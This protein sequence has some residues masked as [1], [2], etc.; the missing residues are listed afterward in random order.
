MDVP[1]AT[2]SR[3][4]SLSPASHDNT[5]YSP[6][7]RWVSEREPELGLGTIQGVGARRVSVTFPASGETR[8]YVREGAPLRRVAFRVGERLRDAGNQPLTVDAVI[9]QNG[10]LHYRCGDRELCETE[11]SGTLSFS[12]PLDRFRLGQ[13]DTPQVFD[14]RFAALRHQSRQRKSPIRGFQGGRIDLLPHQLSIASEVSARLAP[15]VLLA[16][17]VGL[18]KTIEAGLIL[19]RLLLSGRAQRA[20]ILV[21]ESLIHQWFLEL[22]RRFNLW[23]SIYDEARCAAIEAGP[24]EANPFLEDQRVICPVGLFTEH[25]QRLQQA[26][27]AGWDLVI[28]DEAHH[29]AWSPEG[30]SAAYAVVEALGQRVPGLLLLT[31]TPEQLGMASHFARLRLLDPDRFHDLDAFLRESNSYRELAD[32]AERLEGGHTLEALEITRLARILSEPEAQIRSQLEAGDPAARQAWIDA[33]LDQHGTGRVMFRNTRATVAGFPKRIPHLYPLA[34]QEPLNK[35]LLKEWIAD[36]KAETSFRPDFSQDPRIAWL[37]GQLHELGQEK[38]L[39][40]CR[41]RRKAEAIAAALK[42]QLTVKMAV[43]H[44]GLTLIQRDRGAAWFAEPNGA[45]LLICSEIGS[46]G[47]NFQFAHHLVL[48]DLPLDPG[49]LEQR[50]G[51]LDRIGQRADIQIHVPYVLGSPQALLARWYHEGLNAFAENLQGGRELLDRFAPRLMALAQECAT[52]REEVERAMTALI[53]ETQAARS[54]VATR[55]ERG[56]D[57]LLERNSFRPKR[58]AQLIQEIRLQD[59]RRL[60]EDFLLA[61]LELFFIDVDEIAPRTYHIGSTELLADALPGLG[62]DGLTVTCDRARALARED[63][64]FLTWDHPLITGALDLLLGSDPGSTSFA[65]WP[66]DQASGLYLEA[67]YVLECVAP[68]SLH[69]DRFLPPTPVRVMVN[70]RGQDVGD[71]LPPRALA[72]LLKAPESRAFLEQPELRET[73]LPRLVE[74]TQRLADLKLERSIAQARQ[75]MNAEL[76]P[77][78]ARLCDLQKVNPSVRDEEIALLRHQH[79]AL[80]QHLGEARLRLDALRLIHRGPQTR[81]P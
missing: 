75:D 67:I 16:D 46:E 3:P 11:L 73:L 30:A 38:V 45:R 14:L 5:P 32:L 58:A 63:L 56:R 9:E 13:A 24:T 64:Q 69:A 49:L 28:V 8:E 44:E 78:I 34:S 35:T 50:M 47:R 40:I 17:E 10:L 39:L 4:R 80:A 52:D 27:E 2:P 23:F 29:L 60:M 79:E 20:L 12:G 51:R 15:R 62:P 48:F 26:L 57:R 76:E 68:P 7:Q 43:F 1:I 19:H 37:A 42:Q 59:D 65:S 31:A 53:A 6:G 54:E 41:T 61:V 70:H 72:K 77:E 36:A 71:T 74:R 33:M 55:L 21:P 66:D 18:G 22:L 81:L 25:P